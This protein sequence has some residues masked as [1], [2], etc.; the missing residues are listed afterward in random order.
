MLTNVKS[1]WKALSFLKYIL[2]QKFYS[3]T[4]VTMLQPA[5]FLDAGA[6]EILPFGEEACCTG[7]AKYSERPFGDHN[8]RVA[9]GS[10]LAEKLDQIL[11]C[12]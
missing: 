6:K 12:S 5:N 7:T 11:V 1:P 9:Q 3:V 2:Q 4:Q 10:R 8:C